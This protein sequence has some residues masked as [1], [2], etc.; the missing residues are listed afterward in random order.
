MAMPGWGER[1]HI[2]KL[3]LNLEPHEARQFAKELKRM[4]MSSAVL[5]PGLD[6]FS[7]AFRERLLHYAELGEVDID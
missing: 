7:R 1:D 4:N 2:L 5:F 3:N 6:G